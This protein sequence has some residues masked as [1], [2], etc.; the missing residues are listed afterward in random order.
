VGRVRRA[1]GGAGGALARSDPLLVVRKP[2]R[3]L[4]YRVA[5]LTAR[6]RL[7]GAL[8]AERDVEGWTEFALR[9]R[10]GEISIAP[11]QVRSEIEALLRL[12]EELR[13]E[14]VLEVGTARG[15][16][17]FLFTR[18]ASDDAA[19][20]SI[21]LALGA[22][23]RRLYRTFAKRNQTIKTIRADSHDPATATAVERCLDGRP[24]DF[25]FI[26]GDHSYD[27]VKADFMMYS[28]LVREGGCIAFH[29]IVPGRGESASGVPRLWNELSPFHHSREFVADWDQ[30][31]AGIGVLRVTDPAPG[32]RKLTA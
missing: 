12:L 11:A 3:R 10:H 19:L 28:R 2:A 30:G 29:D 25:L 32:L 7:A 13:P 24:V 23:R 21:D 31:W 5:L 22:S 15:G 8:V 9:F 27:G 20:V 17:L 14:T 6:R 1:V 26:D 4:R 18:V 16:T